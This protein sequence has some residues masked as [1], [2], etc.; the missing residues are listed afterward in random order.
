MQ[1]GVKN[2][3][4]GGEEGEKGRA[5]LGPSSAQGSVWIAGRQRVPRREGSARRGIKLGR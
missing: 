4:G 3:G 5:G 2:G 1:K